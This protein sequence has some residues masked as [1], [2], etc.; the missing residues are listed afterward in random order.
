MWKSDSSVVELRTIFELA[1]G[2][3][4]DTYIW[5]MTWMI[6]DPLMLTVP[7]NT[8]YVELEKRSLLF[9]KQVVYVMSADLKGLDT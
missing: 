2:S 3:Y 5:N 1:D 6:G 7:E 9:K 4:K 8:K